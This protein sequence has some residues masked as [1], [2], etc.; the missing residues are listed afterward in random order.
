MP[1]R[2]LLAYSKVEGNLA[3]VFISYVRENR[4]VVDRLANELRNRG[5]TVWLD[6]N[7]IEPGARWKDAVKS[8]IENGSFFIAC[9]SKEY[10]ARDSTYMSDEL[11]TAI[12]ELRRRPT[13]KT[14]FIPVLINE[15]RIPSRR[16]SAVEDLRDIQAIN[17]Q[18]DWDAGI[19]RIIRVLQ[20]DNPVLARIWNLLDIVEKP[21]SNE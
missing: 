10:N 1:N 16:I 20:Y 18:E 5:V 15:T 6:R 7:D 2:F 9:F 8:A 3:H 14:W 17:L 21:F 12:D 4:D 11:I 19:S 13:D